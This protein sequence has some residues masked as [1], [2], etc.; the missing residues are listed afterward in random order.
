MKTLLLVTL[1]TLAACEAPTPPVGPPEN[2][3]PSTGNGDKR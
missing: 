1:F 2:A 3:Q